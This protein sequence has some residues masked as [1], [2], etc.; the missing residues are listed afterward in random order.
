MC[1]HCGR[2]DRGQGHARPPDGSLHADDPR[3]GFD[4]HKGYAT[5]DHLAAVARH[6]Y[7]VQHRGRSGP[8]RCSTRSKL[9]AAD[10]R[11]SIAKARSRAPRRR[12]ARAASMRPSPTTSGSSR[13]SRATGTAPTRSA[14]STFAPARSTRAS[15]S[16]RRIAD[17]LATEGFYPKAAALYKK[18]LKFKPGDEYALLQSA[19][20]PPGRACWPTP[21][22][23]SISWPIGGR[24]AG[25]NKGAAEIS[26]RIG[27]LDPDDLEARL[28]AARPRP[29]WT[30]SDTALREFRDVA[31]RLRRRR[32][33]PTRGS[34]CWRTVVGARSQRSRNRRPRWRRRSSPRATWQRA[35]PY[36][37][38]AD[39]R[40][41]TPSCG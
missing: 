5:A 35:R 29:T 27:T 12:C 41:T 4:R 6:G 21:S 33:G 16:T 34:T 25:D 23:T 7:S 10:C 22:S 36:L 30:I 28:G 17:H 24:R 40:A 15:R 18:I 9:R 1:R 11:R 3:Y 13:R 2:L 32:P 31:Q 14:T 19:R 26:V 20:S 38:D 37:S 39:R 8:R